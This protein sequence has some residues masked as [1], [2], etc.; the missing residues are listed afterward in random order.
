MN[1]FRL[2][3]TL[4]TRDFLAFRDKLLPASGFQ[5]AQF[6]EMASR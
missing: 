4:T 3:E 2:V 1:H 6:R 5:S